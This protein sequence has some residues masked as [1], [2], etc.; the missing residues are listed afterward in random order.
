M[1]QPLPAPTESLTIANARGMCHVV[2]CPDS[3]LMTLT[4]T[5][6]ERGGAVTTTRTRWE[7]HREPVAAWAAEALRLEGVSEVTLTQRSS[8]YVLLFR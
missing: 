6:M 7:L 2:A 4:A 5:N 8:G 3:G 1:S